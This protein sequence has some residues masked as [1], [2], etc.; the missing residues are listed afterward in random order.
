MLS[1]Y[2][3][4]L[5]NIII[6]TAIQLALFIQTSNV[7]SSLNEFLRPILGEYPVWLVQVIVFIITQLILRSMKNQK[8]SG[9][10]LDA[11][12]EKVNFTSEQKEEVRDLL[13]KKYVNEHPNEE[14]L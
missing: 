3:N 4:I 11:V 12:M 13:R 2:K 14:K 5:P 8:R 6:H 1:K 10:Q 9:S 7:E